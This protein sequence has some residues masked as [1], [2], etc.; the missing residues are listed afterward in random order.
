MQG[1]GGAAAPPTLG[2]VGLGEEGEELGIGL[3]IDRLEVDPDTSE[4]VGEFRRLQLEVD[5]VIACT[6]AAC[7]H[8]SPPIA[9]DR[10]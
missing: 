1:F 3:T 2:G 7:M 9:T 6:H 10:H 8:R 4:V 5:M